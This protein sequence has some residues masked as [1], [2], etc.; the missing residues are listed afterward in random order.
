MTHVVRGLHAV[1][2]PAGRYWLMCFS[3]HSTGNGPRKLTR[4]RIATLFEHGWKIHG[5]EADR[6][7]TV[8][9][10]GYAEHP[11]TTAAWLCEIERV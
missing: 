5:I 1:L 3:E 4:Q 8:P 9:G 11:N 2:R 10:R 6:F 7:Q